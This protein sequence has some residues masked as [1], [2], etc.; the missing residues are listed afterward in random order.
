M[1]S[2][3]KESDGMEV[4]GMRETGRYFCEEGER[5]EWG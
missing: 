2:G 1:G 4:R 5:M 3:Q